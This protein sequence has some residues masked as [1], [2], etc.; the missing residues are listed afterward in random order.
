MVRKTA[1]LVHVCVFVLLLHFCHVVFPLLFAELMFPLKL[2]YVIIP[3]VVDT[4]KLPDLRKKYSLRGKGE[5]IF[6]GKKDTAK[7][8]DGK[9]Q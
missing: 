9:R 5:A 2:P 8:V 4:K 6:Q 7:T 3:D 1:C